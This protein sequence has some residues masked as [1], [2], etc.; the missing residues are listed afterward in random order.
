[1]KIGIIGAG[2]IGGTLATRL[3]ALGHEVKIANSHGPQTLRDVAARTGAKPATPAD[4]VNGAELVVVTIPLG[5]VPELSSDLFARRAPAAPIVDTCNYYPSRDGRIEEIEDGMIES[6]WVER[7]IGH[8]VIKAFNNIYFKHLLEGGRPTGS[9][10][11]IA[12]PVAGDDPQAKKKVLQ[13]IDRLG[14]D[15][16]DAGGLDESWRQQPGTPCYTSDF[17]TKQL[18][19]ALKQTERKRPTKQQRT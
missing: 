19:E 18:R 7:Q 1:M 3:T 16:V 11:R 9:A 13:I 8:P 4:A 10:N 15:T 2:N 17:D 5:R 12:L 14:F 6:R